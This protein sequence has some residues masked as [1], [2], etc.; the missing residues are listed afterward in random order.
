MCQALTAAQ[1]AFSESGHATPKCCLF[2]LVNQLI[3]LES[4]SP[5]SSFSRQ[6]LTIWGMTK[7][8]ETGSS[9]PIDEDPCQLLIA[10]LPNSGVTMHA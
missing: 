1:K 2:F 8:G 7:A 10:E 4:L 5:A 3:R 9:L 6:G